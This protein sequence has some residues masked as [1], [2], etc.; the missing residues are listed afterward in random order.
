MAIKDVLNSTNE[1][2]KRV[3]T[4]GVTQGGQTI[5]QPGQ[6]N[7]STG[8][9]NLPEQERVTPDLS[10]AQGTMSYYNQLIKDEEARAAKLE[11][12]RQQAIKDREAQRTKQSGILDALKG[13]GQKRTEELTT[14]GFEPT[15]QFAQQKAQLAEID[16]LYQDYNKVMSDFETQKDAIMGRTGG[17]IDFAN[18]EVAKITRTA[19]SIL[20]LKSSNIK[21]KLAIMEYQQGNFEN[22]QK[23]VDQSISD[24]TAGLTADYNM[25]ESFIEDNNDLITS[26]GTEYTNALNSRKSLILDQIETARQEKQQEFNNMISLENLAINKSQEA[27]LNRESLVTQEDTF[28]DTVNYLKKLRDSGKLTDFSYREQINA[29]MEIGG[30]TEDQR[31]QIESMVNQ[32]MEG[33]TSQTTS[34]TTP[35][36]T[37]VGIGSNSK[38]PIEQAYQTQKDFYKSMGFSNPVTQIRKDLLDMGYK[39]EDIR[40]ITETTWEKISSALT[41]FFFGKK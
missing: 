28:T 14:L 10:S 33:G 23:F 21:S 5:I 38:I 17:T 39:A 18:A 3:E 1:L 19:N 24:Y 35:T 16:A 27:R 4:E 20:G 26:L 13:V 32:A 7:A 25:L 6:Y 15:A 36:S 12:D 40:K 30:Y 22:A 9:I 34:Q 41:N 31:G 11:A 37:S 2:L 8:Q 29:L